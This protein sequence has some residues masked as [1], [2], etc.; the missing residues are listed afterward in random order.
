MRAITDTQ[1]CPGAK[2]FLAHLLRWDWGGGCWLTDKQLAHELE[3]TERT[4]RNHTKAVEQGGH[5]W[6]F[7]DREGMVVRLAVRPGGV[8]PKPAW[9]TKA[10]PLARKN[11]S[12]SSCVREHS[13]V[14]GFEVHAGTTDSRGRSVHSET[15]VVAEHP[16]NATEPSESGVLLTQAGVDQAPAMECLSGVPLKRVLATIR[17][18][19]ESRSE[20]INPGGYIRAAIERRWKL[21][22]WCWEERAGDR[23]T[24]QERPTS[25]AVDAPEGPK[26][27]DPALDP[28][29][30]VCVENVQ[31]T[32][33]RK[34]LWAKAL[35]VMDPEGVPEAWVPP[36]I[37][38]ELRSCWI[39]EAPGGAQ[40]MAPDVYRASILRDHRAAVRS[41]VLLVADSADQSRAGCQS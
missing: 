11:V 30:G 38:R 5:L 10:L 15:P 6:V 34:E 14:K 33:G 39:E 31:P 17:Y 21:P 20:V 41:A 32:C 16:M 12:A 25:A 9:N 22:A 24:G 26:A 40:V 18:V 2:I 29:E 3:C 27:A 8:Y 28:P 7:E 4:V 35:E 1:L 36:G 13:C 37:V 19:Q 23:G